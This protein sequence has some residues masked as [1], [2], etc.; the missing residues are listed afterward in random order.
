MKKEIVYT[1]PYTTEQEIKKAN[2]KRQKLYEKFNSVMV[3]PN[4]MHEVRIIATNS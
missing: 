1:M 3:Y 4:G 2:D